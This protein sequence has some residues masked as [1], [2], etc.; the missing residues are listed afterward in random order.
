MAKV[1]NPLFSTEARGKAGGI[2]FNT[3]RGIATVKIKKSP[4]QPRSARQL[5]VRAYLT[6]LSKAWAGLTDPQRLGWNDYATAHTN[7]DWSVS[8]L[9]STGLNWYVALGT[10]LLL[11]AKALVATA[12]TAVAPAAPS[13]VVL[14]GGSGQI[15][16]AFTAYGGTA[17]SLEVWKYGP[18]SAGITPSRVKARFNKYGPGE[19]TPLVVTGLTAGLNTL[20]IRAVSETDGQVSGWVEA[21]ATVT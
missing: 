8:K 14:T 16:V 15:S 7:S 5:L 4:S 10:R 3:W 9:R 11:Q 13:N 1:T 18:H 6:Q 20:Y 12:P 19:T 21:S 2:V 17:T